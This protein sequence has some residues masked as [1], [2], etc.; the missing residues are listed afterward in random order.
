MKFSPL[1]GLCLWCC[2]LGLAWGVEPKNQPEDTEHPPLCEAFVL[3]DRVEFLFPVLDVPE[4]RWYRKETAEGNLEY[5]WE[6]MLP[7]ERPEYV[8]GIYLAKH[9]GSLQRQGDLDG[10]LADTSWNAVRLVVDDKGE[11]SAVSLP[12][13]QLSVNLEDGGVVLSLLDPESLQRFVQSRPKQALF[14]LLH[15]D[16]VFSINCLAQIVYRQSGSREEQDKPQ[17]QPSRPPAWVH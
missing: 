7:A 1:L 17:A 4:W 11:A 15:P 9:P 13:T 2:G 8:F 14:N 3:N 5:A 16:E 6:V 12:K 10:L